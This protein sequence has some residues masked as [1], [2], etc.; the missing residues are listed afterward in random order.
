[1][2]EHITLRLE[3]FEAG[4]VHPGGVGEG[5]GPKMVGG[6]VGRPLEGSNVG[7]TEGLSVGA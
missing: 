2:F 3:W 6:T 5:L 1:M 4:R 7:A